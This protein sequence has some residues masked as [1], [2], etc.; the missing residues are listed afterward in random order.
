MTTADRPHSKIALLADGA[1]RDVIDVADGIDR[2]MGDRHLYERM[3]RRFRQDYSNGVAPLRGALERG[4]RLLAHR[5]AHTLKGACGMIGA[6]ALHQQASEVEAILRTGEQGGVPAL[7]R[8][9]IALS[10]LLDVLDVLLAGKTPG[11]APEPAPTR[12][13]PSDAALLSQLGALLGDGDGAAVDL[14]EQSSASLKTI[15]GNED[16]QRLARAVN[17]FDFA[18][19]QD[20]LRSATGNAG[21]QR[22]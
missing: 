13:L 22:R 20:T 12:A 3:L 1:T 14:L 16:F 7:D 2:V 4:D 10:K 17:D 9:D 19:A 15:L 8:L 6:R 5:F 18:A 21:A 11:Q